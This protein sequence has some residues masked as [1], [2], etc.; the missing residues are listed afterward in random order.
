[1]EGLGFFGPSRD[2]LGFC[3]DVDFIC[4]QTEREKELKTHVGLITPSPAPPPI[5]TYTHT[6]KVPCMGRA[7]VCLDAT[8]PSWNQGRYC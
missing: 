2:S 5:H 1:M 6:C 7:V 4:L 3:E 8:F